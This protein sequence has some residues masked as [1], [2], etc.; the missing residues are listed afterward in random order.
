MPRLRSAIT[1]KSGHSVI[2]TDEPLRARKLRVGMKVVHSG[3][4][5][6]VTRI[7]NPAHSD[8]PD[9]IL[10][11]LDGFKKRKEP[12]TSVVYHRNDIIFQK[13]T[14]EVLDPAPR[15][16]AWVSVETPAGKKAVEPAPFDPFRRKRRKTQT[17]Q[18][19]GVTLPPTKPAQAKASGDFSPRGQAPAP[20]S[21]LLTPVAGEG[22]IELRIPDGVYEGLKAA[23]DEVGLFSERVVTKTGDSPSLADAFGEAVHKQWW[24]V[25]LNRRQALRFY[26]CLLILSSDIWPNIGKGAWARASLRL[27]AE[28]KEKFAFSSSERFFDEDREQLGLFD[29]GSRPRPGKPAHK[30]VADDPSGWSDF[31]EEDEIPAPPVRRRKVRRAR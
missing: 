24:H 11:N 27:V 29:G 18:E 28:M 22:E 16:E 6:E 3:E 12:A 2:K 4:L 19:Q 9:L 17:T 31:F 21:R 25:I 14:S 1:E 23:W 7:A 15:G 30:K 5:V 10:V 8:H 13:I 26:S 20:R